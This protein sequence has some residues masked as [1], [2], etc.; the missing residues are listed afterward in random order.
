[1]PPTDLDRVGARNR[2][3][4]A[5]ECDNTLVPICSSGLASALHGAD[6]FGSIR[7]SVERDTQMAR[8][9]ADGAFANVRVA[10]DARADAGTS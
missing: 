4:N 10:N 7:R 2:E 3:I 6:R 9:N 1:M 5:R 8:Q